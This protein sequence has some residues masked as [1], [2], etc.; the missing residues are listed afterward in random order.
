MLRHGVTEWNDLY[1]IQGSTDIP[2]NEDGLEMA[3]QTGEYMKNKGIVFDAVYT[4]PLDRA[5]CSA[6]M[7]TGREDVIKDERLKEM[8][9]GKQEGMSVL[10]MKET[11]D[12]PFRCFKNEPSKYDELLSVYDPGAESFATLLARAKDFVKDIVEGKEAA[13]ES[14]G[15][16][17]R[18]LIS[19]HGALD[20]AIVFAMK[21]K[22]KVD[23]FWKGGLLPN[24]GIDIIEYDAVTGEYTFTEEMAFYYDKE[25]FEK[26]PRLLK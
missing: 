21:K 1:K 6:K 4:S 3:R 17:R 9:F 8:S 15:K 16:K 19:G 22:E 5:C 10:Q 13:L 26:A 23:E 24:C 2:L 11:G 7:I 14:E 12:I 20:Q 18:I 25:L